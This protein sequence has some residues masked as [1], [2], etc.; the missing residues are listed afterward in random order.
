MSRKKPFPAAFLFGVKL[1]GVVNVADS[2]GDVHVFSLTPT[3]KNN[4]KDEK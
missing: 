2:A 3:T 1:V 4:Q